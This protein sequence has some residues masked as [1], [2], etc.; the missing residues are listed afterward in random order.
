[1]FARNFF[2]IVCRKK[3]REIFV[4]GRRVVRKL[5]ILALFRLRIQEKFVYEPPGLPNCPLPVFGGGER[6]R[7]G[8]AVPALRVIQCKGCSIAVQ[9]AGHFPASGSVSEKDVAGRGIGRNGVGF[10]R[11][12]QTSI[13]QIPSSVNLGLY[14]YGSLVVKRHF[15]RHCLRISSTVPWFFL[16]RLA[17]FFS[18]WVLSGFFFPFLGFLF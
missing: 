10:A 2:R 15:P 3:P 12:G 1:V 17:C 7:S 4:A 18:F 11:A 14:F 16:S 13:N 6:L 9:L 5:T 8:Q